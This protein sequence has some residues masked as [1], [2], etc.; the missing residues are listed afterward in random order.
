LSP[1]FG[2]NKTLEKLARSDMPLMSH[3]AELR[4]RIIISCIAIFVASIAGFFLWNQ[5]LD[6]A[7]HPYCVAQAHRQNV[8]TAHAQCDLYITDPLQLVT[9]RLSVAVYIGL[10]IASPI[11]LFQLWRFITPGL[12]KKEKRF[13]Y[14]FVLAS[15]LL[16][17]LGA[18]VAWLVFPK[19]ISFFL[20]VGGTH[21]QTL[22]NPAPYLKL[23]FLM[24][25]I[26]GLVFELPVVLVFLELA[27]VVSSRKLRNW[28]RYAIV[29]N[30]A[31]AAVI[32]PS[33]DPYSML[34]MAIPMCL[35][36]EIAIVVG[37]LLKK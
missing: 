31:V 3:L 28:R 11:V 32:T 26:F 25:L 9:T 24:M 36:Y 8:S 4:N 37:R 18:W 16:F 12:H 2:R 10:F 15:V 5:V 13:A 34:A 19:A 20:S 22:F 30:F 6:V 27:G 23:I 17:V 7:S 1:I 14:P 29:G 33:S 21:V 35:F